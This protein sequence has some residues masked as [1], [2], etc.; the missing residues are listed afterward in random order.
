MCKPYICVSESKLRYAFHCRSIRVFMF[1]LLLMAKQLHCLI[2]S[3]V[4]VCTCVCVGLN[5]LPANPSQMAI[6]AN[7]STRIV[8]VVIIIIII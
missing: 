5:W 4:Y 1:I 7:N 2:Q 3:C 8:V 6:I